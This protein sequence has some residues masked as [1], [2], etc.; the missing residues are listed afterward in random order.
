MP[1]YIKQVSKESKVQGLQELR[2]EGFLFIFV[3]VLH[4]CGMGPSGRKF[5]GCGE[6]G[7][8]EG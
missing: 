5:R 6:G 4:N 1:K 3:R 2:E 8:E 7:K